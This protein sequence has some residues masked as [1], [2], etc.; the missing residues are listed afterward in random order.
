MEVSLNLGTIFSGVLV[1][2]LTYGIKLLLGLDK[3]MS[4]FGQWTESHDKQDDERH[5]DLTKRI[6][7]VEQARMQGGDGL[8]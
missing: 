4:K 2:L 5:L 6:G 1:I 8:Q 7:R 3:Q